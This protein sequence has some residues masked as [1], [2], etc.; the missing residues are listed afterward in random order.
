MFENKKRR[1]FILKRAHLFAL[2]YRSMA[3]RINTLVYLSQNRSD[4]YVDIAVGCVKSNFLL[5]KPSS[6]ITK[7]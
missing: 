4:V 2:K 1:A 6:N 5:G 7:E 3:S